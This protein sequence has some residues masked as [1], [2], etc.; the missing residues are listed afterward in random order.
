[1]LLLQYAYPAYIR[2][3]LHAVL[4]H[5]LVYASLESCL[6]HYVTRTTGVRPPPSPLIPPLCAP[7]SLLLYSTLHITHSDPL[8][9]IT[10]RTKI[11]RITREY[12]ATSIGNTVE[13]R[14]LVHLST[15]LF[16]SENKRT[17]DVVPI[18]GFEAAR[19]SS[20]QS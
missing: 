19:L 15:I 12:Y 1:M 20:A 14:A 8:G 17:K 10:Y 18:Q 4:A 11:R 5:I 13:H 16:I 3:F 9:A 6:D 7:Y 2:S